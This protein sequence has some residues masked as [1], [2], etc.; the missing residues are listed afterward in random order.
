MSIS[1]SCFF[2]LCCLLFV[3]RCY[4][5]VVFLLVVLFCF[6]SQY[7]ICLFLHL[8]SCCCFL[9]L[10]LW[11]YFLFWQP[12]KNISQKLGNS[13]NPQMKMQKS[14]HFH[15]NFWTQVCSQIVFLCFFKCCICCSIKIGV[16]APPPPRKI[17]I[18]NVKNWCKHKLKTGPSMLRNI[19]GPAL[20]YK[21]FFFVLLVFETFSSFS[22]QF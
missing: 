11:C 7:Y 20:T 18:S 6:E 8:V 5:V 12:I 9:F 10:L 15:K 2:F 4:F 22:L 3:S 19:I 1:G 16:S 13:E 14:G 17:Q 21:C